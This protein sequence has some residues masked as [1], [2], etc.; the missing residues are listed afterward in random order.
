VKKRILLSQ[1]HPILYLFAVWTRRFKRY[2][3]WCF[4]NKK[5]AAKRT[6]KIL[7]Y[8]L[9]KTSIHLIKKTRRK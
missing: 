6:A 7:P 4:D 2:V 5:Y 1:R 8:R 3:D 9:K